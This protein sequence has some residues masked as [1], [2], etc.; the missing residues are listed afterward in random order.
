MPCF[1]DFIARCDNQFSRA[2]DEV[3]GAHKELDAVTFPAPPRFSASSG[4]SCRRE[5]RRASEFVK[6]EKLC[7]LLFFLLR[8]TCGPY[9]H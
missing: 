1:I 6:R 4:V 3:D 8:S 2:H 7:Y 9:I 5:V